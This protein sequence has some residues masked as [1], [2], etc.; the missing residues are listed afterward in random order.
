MEPVVM[1]PIIEVKNVSKKFRKTVAL[2]GVSFD[3]P[4]GVV[5]AVLGENGAGKT[6]LILSLIH[7]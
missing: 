2:N 6:T 1:A 3:V 5:F 4:P 7:I